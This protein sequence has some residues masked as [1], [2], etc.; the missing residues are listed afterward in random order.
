M[1]SCDTQPGLIPFDQALQKLLDA[2]SPC[3]AIETVPVA[4]AI[5][6][7]LAESP[8]AAVSVPPADN[9]GM[10]GYAVRIADLKDTNALP[11]SQRIPAGTAPQPLQAGSCARIFT[12]AE[13]PAGA[14]AVVMQENVTLQGDRVV[15]PEAV[16]PAENIRPLG[17][18][19]M[20]GDQVLAAGVR[21][22]PS[23]LGMLASVGLAEV[24]V[25]K[26]LKVAI[27]S[28]GDELVEPGKPLAAGQIYNSNRYILAGLLKNLGMEIVDLG[29]VADTHEATLQALTDAAEKADAIIS[30]G[31][32]SVGEEDHVKNAVEE[33][34]RLDMWK[35]RIKPGKPVAH[36]LVGTTPFI[37]L[38]GNPTSTLIT[39]CLLARPFLQKL[40]GA[41]YKAPLTLPV[42]A[43][44]VRGR[45]N[46][47]QEFLRAR[48]E[49]GRAVPFKN[50]SSGVLSSAS[51]ADGVAI[52]PSETQIAEG[53]IVDFI[54]FA[55][56]LN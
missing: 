41:A 31:G 1:H 11:L 26:P 17:Q 55:E 43:G 48:I 4:D 8:V 46:L 6:R 22:Q 5:G 14:D 10:D 29:C 50:Q 54:P 12:G 25:Y 7:V 32:V 40:Q 2:A 49:N 28:T 27:L 19:L 47:R 18:D 9:S 20:A 34:G 21:L 15:F 44:F 42:A 51:W 30:T 13:I 45:A 53:D 3:V 56:L 38:P 36:G 52:V 23:D 37:G 33:L 39:F 24:Q 35:L 16:K